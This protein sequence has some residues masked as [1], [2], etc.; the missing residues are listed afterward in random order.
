M[1]I[2]RGNAI[3]LLLAGIVFTLGGVVLKISYNYYEKNILPKKSIE[4]QD[5]YK[6]TQEEMSRMGAYNVPFKSGKL[7][8][9]GGTIHDRNNFTIVLGVVC[10]IIGLIQKISG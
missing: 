6:K 8:C 9:D 10:L 7:I 3:I 5:K 2:N 1:S 4:K